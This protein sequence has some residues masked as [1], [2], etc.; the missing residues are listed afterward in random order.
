MNFLEEIPAYGW[1][2]LLTPA[3]MWALFFQSKAPVPTDPDGWIPVKATLPLRLLGVISTTL[4]FLWLFISIGVLFVERNL[5]TFI[6]VA[7]I[8]PP[9]V[10][11]S[12]YTSYWTL[13]IRIRFN[14]AGL[15]HHGIRKK[16]FLSW[17]EVIE[18]KDT[19]LFGTLTVTRDKKLP[20]PKFF[21]GFPQLT[22]QA[23]KNGIPVDNNVYRA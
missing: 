2:A 13:F 12:L 9:L 17:S 5:A 3:M 7:M 6:A 14:D 4:T 18:V 16:L 15:E 22:N 8:T 11:L 20:T 21:R 10:V 19:V 1:A 23:R